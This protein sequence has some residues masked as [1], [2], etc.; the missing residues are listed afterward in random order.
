MKTVKDKILQFWFKLP[1][2][3]RGLIIIAIPISCLIASLTVFSILQLQLIERENQ[4]NKAQKIQSETRRLI[5]VIVNAETGIQGYLITGKSEYLDVYQFA[6][7]VIPESFD[8]LQPLIKPNPK[9]QERLESTKKLIQES[10][11]LLKQLETKREQINTNPQIDF[12][13]PQLSQELK[14]SKEILEEAKW[15]L[16]LI[17]TMEERRL[18]IHQHNLT[19]QKQLYWL[20]L[21]IVVIIGTCGALIA[22]YLIYRLD[23]ELVER[24]NRLYQSNQLLSQVNEQLQLFTA[25]ASHELRAPLAAVLSNAQVGLLAPPHDLEQPRKRLEKI[26]SLVKSMSKLIDNLLFLAS[27]DKILDITYLE[28]VDLVSLLNQLAK[29]FT[30]PATAK[31]LFLQSRLPDYPLI[32]QAEKTLLHQAI[33]NLLCNAIKY[34]SSGSKIILSLQFQAEQILIQVEDNGIGIPEELLP[35]IFKPFYRIDKARSRQTGGFGLGLAITQQIIQAHGGTI[36]VKSVVE[37]GSIFKI[38]LPRQIYR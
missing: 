22:V 7:T 4:V 10:F 26:V 19:L 13:L 17:S 3:Q 24:E 25:N 2:R 29:E 18:I 33:A 14:Q 21:G 23:E 1:I 8:N 5:T 12:P 27:Q 9:Q 11:T 38:Q 37:Q 6:L 32:I 15:Y 35:L 31:N 20:L 16:Y 34:S 36:K 30:A 28:A